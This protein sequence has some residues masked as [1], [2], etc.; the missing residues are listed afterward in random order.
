[1]SSSIVSPSVAQP[2]IAGTSAQ[3]PPSSASCTIT[4]I[5]ISKLHSRTREH[6]C[7]S[8][9]TAFRTNTT[10]RGVSSLKPP[11]PAP[12]APPVVVSEDPAEAK[13]HAG[14]RRLAL[15]AR[16]EGKIVISHE[17]TPHLAARLFRL[18]ARLPVDLRARG[19]G[20]RRGA[21]SGA[22]TAPRTTTTRRASSAPR[23]RATPSASII[24]NRLLHPLRRKGKKADAP[25]RRGLARYQR[26]GTDRLGRCARHRRRSLRQGRGAARRRGGVALFLRRHHGPGAARRHQSA[27]PRRRA[28]PASSTRSAPTRPGPASS[29]APDASPGPT[30]ARWRKLR[31]RRDLGHQRGRDAGQRHDPCRPGAEGA[32]RADRGHRRLP[33]RD[34]EAGRHRPLPEAGHRRGASPARSCMSSSAT[35]MPT[36]TISSTTPMCRA[37]SRR[38]FA[39][40]TPEWA[41]AITGLSVA[42][43]EAFAQ[44]PSATTK[45]TFFRLGYG[46]TPLA[47]RRRSTCTPPPASPAVT[48]A[49]QYEGGGAFHTNSGIF[50][51]DKTMIEG[52]DI[53][54]PEDPP[55]RPVADRRGPLRRGRA[56][57]RRAAG[58]GDARS[59][60]PTRCRS[61][62]SRRRSSAA[63]PATTSSSA[64][65]SR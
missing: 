59:R 3:K 30:R 63:S 16:P 19:R 17:S 49:W 56:A 61:R 24:P 20:D 60:T 5:F 43:I 14:S 57:V 37:S 9:K 55:A 28:I 51:L 29:P 23:S 45:R 64:C 53:A 12:A 10:S 4:L 7:R 62:R 39:T 21:P 35:A 52:L 2:G 38:I 25:R 18:P 1:M 44:A 58:D 40:R 27:A 36:G 48:G 65:T 42:E 33:Q 22:C 11:L 13:G 41:A 8:H 15:T 34:D 32:R 54:D 6:R 31:P 47:E 50:G 26:L 46:F